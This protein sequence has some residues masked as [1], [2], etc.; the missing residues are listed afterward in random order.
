MNGTCRFRPP[1]TSEHGWKLVLLPPSD[2][3]FS[4]FS[5]YLSNECSFNSQH[6][7]K[8]ER[9]KKKCFDSGPANFIVNSFLANIFSLFDLPLSS[10]NIACTV[11]KIM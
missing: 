6:N 3:P 10:Y 5:S 7:S 1:F 4:D 11:V 2:I 8:T 9:N